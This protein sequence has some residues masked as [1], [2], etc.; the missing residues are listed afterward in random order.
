VIQNSAGSVPFIG[1]AGAGASGKSFFCQEIKRILGENFDIEALVVTMDGYHYYRHQLDQM[2]DPEYAHA[3]RG[4]EFTFD[5]Q[6]F[7]KDL[8]RAQAT[9]EGSFPDFD[10]AK[11][12]PEENK[13]KFDCKKHQVV[14]VEGL[15]VLLNKEPWAQ[16]KRIFSRTF[17]LDTEDDLII[18]R[19]KTRMTTQMGLSEEEAERRIFENDM[20]NANFIKDNTSMEEHS[21]LRFES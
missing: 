13:I 11:K 5:A 8:K 15:Y 14:L 4:A 20:V 17:F 9:G 6:R 19:H 10:H 21:V 12:D 7:V 3:R 18:K 2:E 1:V 16:L